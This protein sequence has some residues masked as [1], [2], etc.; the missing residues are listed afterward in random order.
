[1]SNSCLKWVAILP[2]KLDW[3]MPARSPAKHV[4]LVLQLTTQRP[5]DTILPTTRTPSQSNQKVT[6]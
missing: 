1:M 4:T 3:K 5:K 6:K 2:H